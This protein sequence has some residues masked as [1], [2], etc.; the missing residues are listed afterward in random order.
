MSSSIIENH[1]I[2]NVLLELKHGLD[3]HG[4]AMLFEM[5]H[6]WESIKFHNYALRLHFRYVTS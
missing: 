3:H 4:E 2:S 1:V 5:T 6:I